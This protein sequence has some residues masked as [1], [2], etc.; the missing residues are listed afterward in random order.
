MVLLRTQE[1]KNYDVDRM[2]KTIFAR[3]MEASKKRSMVRKKKERR[4]KAKERRKSKKYQKYCLKTLNEFLNNPDNIDGVFLK[5]KQI[6]ET[7][8]KRESNVKASLYNSVFDTFENKLKR[9]K[10]ASYVFG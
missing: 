5:L 1:R 3:E 7:V 4:R 6:E 8:I 9:L 2:S 10:M